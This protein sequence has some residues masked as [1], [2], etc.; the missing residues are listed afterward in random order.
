MKKKTIFK[1]D[2][3]SVRIGKRVLKVTKSELDLI[4]NYAQRHFESVGEFVV[5][6]TADMNKEGILMTKIKFNSKLYGSRELAAVVGVLQAYQV[7]K[8]VEK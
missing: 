1:K 3:K 5:R 8:V 6:M 2:W 4:S 7:N